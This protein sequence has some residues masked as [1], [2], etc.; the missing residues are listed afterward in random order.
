M[1]TVHQLMNKQFVI[2]IFNG[3]LFNRNINKDCT[4]NVEELPKHYAK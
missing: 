2:D 3:I 1:G 4:H